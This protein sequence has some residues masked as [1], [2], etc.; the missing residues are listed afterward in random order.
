M[1]KGVLLF[2]FGTFGSG[3]VWWSH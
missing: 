1:L 3:Q 2:W